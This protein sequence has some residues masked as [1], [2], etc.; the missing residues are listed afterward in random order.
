M[1]TSAP[2]LLLTVAEVAARAY[3]SL[4]GRRDLLCGAGGPTSWQSGFR[5]IRR[6]RRREV[7]VHIRSST[8]IV[9]ILYAIPLIL[10]PILVALPIWWSR[11]LFVVLATGLVAANYTTFGGVRPAV[12]VTCS[13]TLL[14]NEWLGTAG[15]VVLVTVAIL[16]GGLTPEVADFIPA[17][18]LGL[19]LGF[20]ST[21]VLV[22][23][24]FDVSRLEGEDP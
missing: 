10:S 23:T 13:R 3:W 2:P 16:T 22:L 20:V 12:T 7:E 1:T 9:L 18:L 5:R 8:R 14:W 6:Q 17:I 15:V 11:V 24:L 19:A 21:G 4:H